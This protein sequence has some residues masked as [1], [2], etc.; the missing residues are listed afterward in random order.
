[1]SGLFDVH[2]LNDEGMRK[3]ERIAES[4]AV[5]LKALEGEVGIIGTGSREF[6]LCRTHLEVAGF[7]AKKAMACQPENQAK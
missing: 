6:A 5:L 2:R 4:F 3:A 1:V 7:F